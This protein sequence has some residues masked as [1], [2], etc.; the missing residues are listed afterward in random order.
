MLYVLF[1]AHILKNRN[2]GTSNV[3][4][5]GQR[6]VVKYLEAEHEFYHGQQVQDL[7]P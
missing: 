4:R 5:G 6:S 7:R 3:L 2:K 1:L